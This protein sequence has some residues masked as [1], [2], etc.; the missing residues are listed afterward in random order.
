MDNNNI[1]ETITPAVAKL[2]AAEME[3]RGFK[4]NI[5]YL[6]CFVESIEN[7]DCSHICFIFDCVEKDGVP[8]I[9]KEAV[10]EVK[11]VLEAHGVVPALMRDLTR[12]EL[13]E[14]ATSV[15]EGTDDAYFFKV[16]STTGVAVP[17]DGVMPVELVKHI[18]FHTPES[19]VDALIESQPGSVK[20][21]LPLV[22]VGKH[23]YMV[24][25]TQ[26]EW[27]ESLRGFDVGG[28]YRVYECE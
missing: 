9:N 22:R 10:S 1:S 13:F 23:R 21:G 20:D 15:G 17:I 24:A 27:L 11:K 3:K 16:G 26:E 19:V 8:S 2:V 28:S 6:N 25:R 5:D 7:G 14:E 4:T 12:L 18:D